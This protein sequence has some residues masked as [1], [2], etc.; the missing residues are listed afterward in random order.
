MRRQPRIAFQSQIRLK[1]AGRDRG[2]IAYVQNLS[3]L[4]AFVTTAA[5]DAPEPGT[6]VLCR[7]SIADVGRLVRGRVVWTSTPREDGPHNGTAGVG[8]EFLSLDALDA[9]L[10]RRL[11]E[12]GKGPGQ[13]VDVW[14]EG[15]SSPVRCQAVTAGRSVRLTTRLPF[16]RPASSV[17][18]SFKDYA[19]AGDVREGTVLSALLGSCDEE[20]VPHLRLAVALVD[21]DSVRGTIEVR[22]PA[23]PQAP[24]APPLASTVVDPALTTPQLPRWLTVEG[25]KAPEPAPAPTSPE[26]AAAPEA[27]PSDAAFEGG[28]A[29]R[30]GQGWW[31]VL[32]GAAVGA[33]LVSTVLLLVLPPAARSASERTRPAAAS[34]AAGGGASQ[35]ASP[36]PIRADGGR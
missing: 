2:V 5:A 24:E 20:G 14:F 23:R 33:V 15:L 18:L 17:K 32:I 28:W 1:P 36:T 11:V 6:S 30:L 35:A 4:G 26:G 21:R 12:P 27:G 19:P 22:P 10:I 7:F 31:P 3:M 34:P 29:S 9:D 8:L 16:M 25:G 13:P